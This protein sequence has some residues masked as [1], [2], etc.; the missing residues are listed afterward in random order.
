MNVQ[1]KVIE[2]L[3]KRFLVQIIDTAKDTII[4]IQSPKQNELNG[5]SMAGRT[6]ESIP[7]CTQIYGDILDE[8]SQSIA[9][10]ISIKTNKRVAVSCNVQFDTF[11]DTKAFVVA[12][13]VSMLQD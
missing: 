13:I 11:N 4:V 3:N 9:T 5:L 1:Y 2:H 7:S 10:L 8:Q 12:S 6:I